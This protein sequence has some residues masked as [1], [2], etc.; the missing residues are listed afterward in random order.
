MT[1]LLGEFLGTAFLIIL[2]GGVVA[3]VNL[4]RNYGYQAGW[5]TITTGWFIAVIIGVF[6]ARAAG[7]PNADINPAVSLSKYLLGLDYNT[8]QL[9]ATMAAQVLGGF[10][11]GIIVW[12][13]YL[14]H[15]RETDD[16]LAKRAVFCT[17]PAIRCYPANLITEAIGTAV[18]IIG[19]GAIFNDA[20]PNE[21]SL[22][23]GSY[24]VGVLVWG[25]G[26]SL[27]GAT[28]YAINPAR[29]LGPRLA[30]AILPIPNK[31]KPDWCYAWVPIVGPFIG[32]IIGA[33]VW[34]Y[35]L[36]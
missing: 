25:I 10:V 29:D 28:G 9:L 22:G 11:G 17:T 27:G 12:L 3:N 26:L 24:L 20:T 19:I 21:P 6:V 31:A 1:N 5:L 8:T 23:L 32:A 13:T 2:G 18:L 16:A 15:W 7:A 34:H 33:L 36:R 4:K 14:A 30:H 35:L